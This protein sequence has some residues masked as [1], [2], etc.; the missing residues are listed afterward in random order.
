MAII[1][2]KNRCY[3]SVMFNS[4]TLEEFPLALNP[5]P[6]MRSREKDIFVQVS[7]AVTTV[8]K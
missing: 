1:Y 2:N 4:S 7:S 3:L 5:R 6:T 8:L